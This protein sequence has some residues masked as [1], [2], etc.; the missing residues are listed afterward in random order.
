MIL[1]ANQPYFAPFPGF[2]AKAALA[3]VLVILDT[4]QFPRGTT[5]VSRNRFKG[6]Q[7]PLWVTVPVWKKGLGLQRIRDV[8]ICH[9]GPWAA[10]LLETFRHAYQNAPWFREHM[11]VWEQV[12]EAR[13][14]RLADLD[15]AL[16]RHLMDVLGLETRLVLL[17]GLGIE[18]TGHDLLVEIC[19]RLGAD[20]FLAQEGARGFLQ[21][22]PFLEAGLELRFFRP[23]SPVYPQLWGDFAGNL[24]AFDLAWCCGPKS[25]EILVKSTP[26]IR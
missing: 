21:P 23:P 9:E 1:A 22:D 7:G 16:I 10:K 24:S 26:P 25:G 5:W 20:T 12:L 8:R 14:E 4:V 19:R 2:F 6:P 17:S 11:A 13:F 18:A 15:L 3:D